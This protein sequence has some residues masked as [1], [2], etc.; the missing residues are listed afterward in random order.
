MLLLLCVNKMIIKK[1]KV[2]IKET[3][4]SV[5]IWSDIPIGERIVAQNNE[6]N[7]DWLVDLLMSNAVKYIMS[8]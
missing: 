7:R 5:R 8:I 2:K 6:R 3:V 4:V 1:D